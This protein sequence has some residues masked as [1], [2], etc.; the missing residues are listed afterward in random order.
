MQERQLGS[1]LRQV[2][3]TN[4][5]SGGDE[6]DLRNPLHNAPLQPDAA[7]TACVAIADQFRQVPS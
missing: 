6:G 7:T 2:L 1:V 3:T 5:V 4:G